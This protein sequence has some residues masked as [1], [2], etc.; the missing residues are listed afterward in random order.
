MR[1]VKAI[2]HRNK[3]LSLRRPSKHQNWFW[4]P[5]R[6]S[7]LHDLV[8]LGYATVPHALLM[9]LCERWH[10]VTNTFHMPLGEMTVTLDDV[11][12]LTH[13]QIEGR[14]LSHGKK[15]L[16]HEACALLVRH[17]GVSQ[18]EAEKICGTEYGGYISYPKPKELYTRYPGRANILADTEV[19][20]SWK[21]W[22]GLGNFVWGVIFYVL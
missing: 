22:G 20:R 4:N 18:M 9:T 3:I 2:N 10:P 13:L 5:L 17:L 21:S 1:V 16:R 8:Y 19:Q 11:A 14:M 6:E 7:G 15:M 12:C